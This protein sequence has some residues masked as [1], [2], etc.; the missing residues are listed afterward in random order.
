MSEKK[1]EG[2]RKKVRKTERALN[3]HN[4]EKERFAKK[5]KKKERWSRRKRQRQRQRYRE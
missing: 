3:G 5:R 1:K 2:E 4:P